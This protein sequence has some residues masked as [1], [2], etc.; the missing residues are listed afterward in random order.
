MTRM[1]SFRHVDD[2]GYIA[3]ASI[4]VETAMGGLWY[5]IIIVTA[6]LAPIAIALLIGSFIT[7]RLVR[8]TQATSR[9][10][11][12]ALADNEV[13]FR[14]IHHRVKNNLQSVGSLLQMQPIPK[15]IKLDMGQRIAAMSAVHE[16]IYRSNVFSR[17]EVKDYLHILIENIRAGHNPDVRVLEAIENVAVEK[18]AATPL[19]L[20]FNE[21]VSNAFKHAFSDG[22]QGEVS[23]TLRRREDDRGELT[24]SDNGV[25]FDPEQPVRGI[26]RRLIGALTQQ[27]QGESRFVSAPGSGATFTLIF[28]LASPGTA[29]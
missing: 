26:G 8:R 20:I 18:D 22:R 6:L 27:I 7:A 12:T 1:V 19:G 11:T 4:S 2:L 25:G 13:L 15:E 21:V 5:S 23:I 9:S 14:E 17:V 29:P 3:L 24:V 28:P 10:L 16:H